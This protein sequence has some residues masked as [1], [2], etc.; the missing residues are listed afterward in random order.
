MS[1]TAR[2]AM[3]DTVQLASLTVLQKVFSRLAGP[4]AA[5]LVAGTV[6][7][8]YKSKARVAGTGALQKRPNEDIWVQISPPPVQTH[9]PRVSGRR[10]R[11][12]R[13]G[14]GNDP[15][16]RRRQQSEGTPSLSSPC[17]L[18]SVFLSS[19]RPQSSRRPYRD[20]GGGLVSCTVKSDASNCL[21]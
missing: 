16:R 1:L 15:C 20:P 19:C 14:S 4:L 18:C 8:L 13:Q 2:A 3:V 9:P 5:L 10:L 17:R 21:V 7:P 11:S 12:H 6:C